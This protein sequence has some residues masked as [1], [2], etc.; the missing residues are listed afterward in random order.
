MFFNEFVFAPLDLPKS[1][2]WLELD[3]DNNP[4]RFNFRYPNV[5]NLE[6]CHWHGGIVS[7]YRGFF[8]D[9]NMAAKLR[10]HELYGSLEENCIVFEYLCRKD[11]LRRIVCF[12]SDDKPQLDRWL[13]CFEAGQ[14][15]TK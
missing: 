12:Y 6:W 1:E 5:D 13:N 7:F 4:T 15:Q 8:T 9:E 3:E 14:Q 2:L 10:T 11:D